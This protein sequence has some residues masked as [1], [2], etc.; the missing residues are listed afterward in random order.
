MMEHYLLV[1]GAGGGSKSIMDR[2]SDPEAI[3]EFYRCLWRCK[4][5]CTWVW[6]SRGSGSDGRTHKRRCESRAFEVEGVRWM[7]ATGIRA[8][9]VVEIVC[10]STRIDLLF[11]A[12]S[13][14]PKITFPA[15]F[16]R[17]SIGKYVSLYGMVFQI[18]YIS[19]SEHQLLRAIARRVADR[20]SQ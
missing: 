7:C 16:S 10:L 18:A 17:M 11:E 20:K 5:D 12:K 6:L 19:P 2:I 9:R 4:C 3:D 14:S 15:S 13:R 8:V 1:A